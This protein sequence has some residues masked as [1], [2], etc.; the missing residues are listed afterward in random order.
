MRMMKNM[1]TK[2]KKTLQEA[3][4]SKRDKKVNLHQELP[5]A[6]G[7]RLQQNREL[8]IGVEVKVLPKLWRV[9]KTIIIQQPMLTG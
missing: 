8:A 7:L 1:D 4:Q 5:L 6:K 2:Q 9:L 3:H